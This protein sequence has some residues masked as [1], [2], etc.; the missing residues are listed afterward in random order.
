MRYSL[1]KGFT[2]IELIIVVSIFT[3]L[4]ALATPNF[5]GALEKNKS[6]STVLEL[7]HQLSFAREASIVKYKTITICASDNTN[8]CNG[9]RNWS[10]TKI[11]IRFFGPK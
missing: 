5:I 2:L 9:S 11:I 10:N 4:G 7:Y 8:S 6:R 1:G 3:L